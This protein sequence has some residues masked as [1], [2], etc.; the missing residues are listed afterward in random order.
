[1]IRSRLQNKFNKHKTREH[2]ENYARQRNKCTSLRQKTIKKHFSKLCENGVIREAKVWSS[3]KPV[4]SN[5]GCHNNNNNLNL[6]EDGVIISD[7]LKVANT[8]NDFY[9]NIVQNISGKN[10]ASIPPID[11][12]KPH[13]SDNVIDSIID[14]YKEHPSIELIKVNLTLK[15]H[16]KMTLLK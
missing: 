2:W 3:I 1:M 10:N 4:M 11:S 7:E 8:F 15:K 12:S 13:E 6:L 16:P 14:K 9:V 5:K